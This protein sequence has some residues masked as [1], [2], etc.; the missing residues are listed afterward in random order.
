M[1]RLSKDFWVGLVMLTGSAIYWMGAGSIPISP[2]DGEVN[3]AAMPRF[4]ATLLAILSVL[5]M[6][7]ALLLPPPPASADESERSEE[8]T[9][10]QK[11]DSDSSSTGQSA[12]YQ[13]MRAGGLIVIGALYLVALPY[14]GYLISVALLVAAVSAYM[15]EK[16]TLKMALIAIALA[17]GYQLFFVQ[18]LHI[19]LPAGL[20]GQLKLF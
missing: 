5:L 20:L 6:A 17:I 8:V 15:G 19:Q 12:M 3:A 2:L 11:A 7:R 4:L 9:E 14:L 13:H 10:E 16:P 18:L 1:R